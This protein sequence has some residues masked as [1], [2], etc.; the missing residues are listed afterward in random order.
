MG[1]AFSARELHEAARPAAPNL[2]LTTA[3]R[4]IERW[5]E[6]R[7][8][9]DAGSRDGEAVV[10]MC[11]A[12]GHH[13][14]LV[15]VDCGATSILDGCALTSAAEAAAKTGFTLL[16]QALGALPARC[17]GCAGRDAA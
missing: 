4:A 6:E 15:C 5:R 7:L 8:V 13:H 3:Y 9:E 2:G 1:R 10:V 14:H 11:S 16:D 17:A 12:P